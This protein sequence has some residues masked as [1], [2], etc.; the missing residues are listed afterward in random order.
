MTL[1][2][3]FET[4]ETVAATSSRTE[5]QT[6][7]AVAL[8]DP[9]FRAVCIYAYD[10]FITFGIVPSLERQGQSTWGEP[11]ATQI[12]SYLDRLARR[13]YTGKTAERCVE[14]ML[15][16]LPAGAGQLLVRILNKDLR[17]GFTA[18]TLNKVVKR[19]VPEYEPMAAHPFEAKRIKGWPVAGE[20]KLDG[21]RLQ[22]WV[23]YENGEAE[24]RSRNGLPMP[25]LKPL[26]EAFLALSCPYAKVVFDGEVATGAFNDSVGRTR[27][28][29]TPV[30]AASMFVFDLLTQEEFTSGSLR[31]YLTRRSTLE[32]VLGEPVDGALALRV[33]PQRL[34]HSVAEVMAY[35]EEVRA[36][37]VG[38]FLGLSC[39][40]P[41]EGV[42]VKTLTGGYENK[43]S[44]HWLKV[45][46][47]ETE[48]LRVMGAYQ[49]EPGTKY[50]GK[51]GGVI[52]DR[53]GVE[54]RVGGGFSDALRDE[55]LGGFIG[56]LIEVEYH[57]VT[58]D[59]SLRH[60][61]F[62]RFRDDKDKGVA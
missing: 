36:M 53:N 30:D 20:P 52:V 55:P 26:A 23:D 54:V 7:L 37:T 4:L 33:M 48:D 56:R 42:I 39:D 29:S 51:L 22:V 10:P 46:A 28:K 50:A 61:R 34:L 14:E 47:E 32:D 19:L 16:Q 44:H 3:A 49:G 9:I 45:K 31:P 59:G 13:E 18:T 24:A 2:D 60:P 43:R 17:A 5:K 40:K 58:P 38:Q 41:M 6:L 62:V 12:F 11:D 57:E 27:R 15:H 35:Y 25:A 21:L 8:K 1:N